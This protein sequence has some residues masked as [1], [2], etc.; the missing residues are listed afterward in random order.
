VWPFR[1]TG[2]IFAELPVS[3]EGFPTGAEEGSANR[4]T[5]IQQIQNFGLRWK[6]LPSFIKT[7][8]SQAK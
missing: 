3:R 6:V 1:R 7:I 8:F 5:L 2:K 4:Q